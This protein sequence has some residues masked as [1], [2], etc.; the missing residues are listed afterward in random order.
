M[1]MNPNTAI[2][3]ALLVG[4]VIGAGIFSSFNK[5]APGLVPTSSKNGLDPNMAG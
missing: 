1:A 2:A 5:L 4:M 3:I